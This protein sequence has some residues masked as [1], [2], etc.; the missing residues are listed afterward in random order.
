MIVAAGVAV[1]VAPVVALSPVEGNQVYVVPPDADN[2]VELPAQSVVLPAPSVI[3]GTVFTV[4][5]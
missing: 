5:V 1:T 2:V 3:D 4:M